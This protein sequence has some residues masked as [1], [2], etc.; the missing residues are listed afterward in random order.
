MGTHAL[1]VQIFQEKG[2][3]V[4][5]IINYKRAIEIDKEHNKSIKN[6]V[7]CYLAFGS[8]FNSHG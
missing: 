1:Y 2:N 8:N 4:E 5:A 7:E 3:F 6:L